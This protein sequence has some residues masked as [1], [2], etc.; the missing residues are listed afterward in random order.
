M[1]KCS[2]KVEIFLFSFINLT[3]ETA[4]AAIQQNKKGLLNAKILNDPPPELNCLLLLE[5]IKK[6]KK[7]FSAFSHRKRRGG[8]RSFTF[9]EE[10][11]V[12]IP[13]TKAN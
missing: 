4:E 6:N 13:Q 9:K 10:R 3:V 11:C 5:A 12:H 7:S 2:P 8:G 1:G